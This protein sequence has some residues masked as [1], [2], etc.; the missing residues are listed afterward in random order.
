MIEIIKLPAIM[1][2]KGEHV[3]ALFTL[4]AE[5]NGRY[6]YAAQTGDVTMYHVFKPVIGEARYTAK[7][8]EIYP[9]TRDFGKTAFACARLE[10]AEKL[11][12]T[13]AGA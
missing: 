5:E 1:H 9:E 13:L 11:L 8:A 7:P 4:L 10:C 2:G 3:G 12:E 6:L